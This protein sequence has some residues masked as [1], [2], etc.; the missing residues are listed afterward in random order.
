MAMLG[1]ALFQAD[2]VVCW[3]WDVKAP[4]NCAILLQA[5]DDTVN[6]VDWGMTTAD[7]LGREVTDAGGTELLDGRG[8]EGG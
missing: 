5:A 4:G 6:D 2:A 8:E 1:L 3:Y 7:P